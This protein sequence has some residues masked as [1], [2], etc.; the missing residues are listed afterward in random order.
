[1][2]RLLLEALKLRVFLD[3]QDR[4]CPQVDSIAWN[5]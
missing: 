4:F 3:K 1:L 5:R 2:P